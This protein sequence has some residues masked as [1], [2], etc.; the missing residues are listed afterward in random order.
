DKTSAAIVATNY[1]GPLKDLLGSYEMKGGPIVEI[2]LNDGHVALVV[3]GQPAYPLVEKEKDKLTSPSLPD[4][5]SVSVKRDAAGKV[6]A[7]IIKQPEGEFEFARLAE[8]NASISISVDDLLQKIIAAT[9]GEENL[10]KHKSRVMTADLVLEHQGLTG[11]I[12]ASAKAPNL[13]TTHSK[14]FALGKE[15][16]TS[17][18]YFDGK[19]GVELST[20][21]PP[22][23]RTGKALEDERI[24][25]DFNELLDWKKLYK[26]VVI[27]KMEKVGG[28]DAY[29]VVK[30]PEKGN[31]VTDYISAKT[32]LLLRRDTFETSV[33][34][35]ITLP[36]HE[37]YSDYRM[38]DG[39]MIP[40]KSVTTIPAIGDIVTTIKDVKFNVDIP[41]AAF[42]AAEKR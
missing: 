34:K 2:K 17:D 10:R 18:Q 42:H 22:Q 11:T 8:T 27:K 20:F 36:V 6:S 13:I 21:L 24:E 37:V 25:A 30:T 14:L 26:S 23:V 32:F 12:V 31:E 3:E 35:G 41:D 15:I 28:E 1:D 39:Q 16:G 7:I 33:E 38:I 40:F 5:Y 19:Q 29:V 9:G 4:A